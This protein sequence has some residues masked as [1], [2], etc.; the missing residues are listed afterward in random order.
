MKKD[1]IEFICP[2]YYLD[3]IINGVSEGLTDKEIECI[4]SVLFRYCCFSASEEPFFTYNNDFNNL[5][6]DCVLLTAI[7]KD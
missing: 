5:G 7:K 6:G 3:Y 2:I 4:N 1:I